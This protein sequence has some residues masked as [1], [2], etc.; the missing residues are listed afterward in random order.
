MLAGMER[1]IRFEESRWLGD[2][3]T[4]RVH[5]LDHCDD[6]DVIDELV[7]SRQ[8]ASFGPDTL[9]EAENRGYRPCNCAGAVAA[10]AADAA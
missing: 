9:A 5:D 8:V 6:Q 10:R 3:R 1:P 4:Q 7:D 2:K